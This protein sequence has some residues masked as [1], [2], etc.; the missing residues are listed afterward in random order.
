MLSPESI[1]ERYRHMIANRILN[2]ILTVSVAVVL[3]LQIVTTFVL[4]L[5]VGLTCGLLFFP[6][7]FT[8][9]FIWVLLLFPLVGLSWICNKAPALRNVI[10]IIFIPWAVI[11]YTFVALMPSW[12][13]FDKR[14]S[15]IMLCDSWPFTWELRQH[16]SVNLDLHDYHDPAA[17]AL[18]EVV[19]RISAHD[20]LKQRVLMRAE[21]YNDVA[22][23]QRAAEKNAL[24]ARLTQHGL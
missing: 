14:A 8:I 3:P 18:K 23:M 4:G 15:K 13:D 10:G 16:L 22:T 11:A 17:T 21:A 20:P 9:N 7:N 6:I 2:A 19:E 12:G 1:I 5:V 24:R